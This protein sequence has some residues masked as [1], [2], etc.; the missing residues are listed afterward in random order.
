[1]L[2]KGA[3]EPVTVVDKGLIS[4]VF[5]ISKSSGGYHPKLLTTKKFVELFLFKM[6]GIII[7]KG[8]IRAGDFFS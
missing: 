1:M 7:L 6:E 8:M 3:I 5:I 4:G 2:S